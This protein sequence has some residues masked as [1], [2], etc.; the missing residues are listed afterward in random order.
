[1]CLAST[2]T[3]SSDNFVRNLFY[4]VLSFCNGGKPSMDWAFFFDLNTDK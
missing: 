1:M 2:I 4:L 3:D